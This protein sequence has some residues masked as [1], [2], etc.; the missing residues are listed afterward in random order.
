MKHTFSL[1]RGAEF[2]RAWDEGKAWSH[3]RVI[4][5]ARANGM[6]TCRFGFVAGKKIGSIAARNRAKR[7]L[8]EAVR[9]HLPR[10]APG[11][12][13]IWI[14]RAGGESIAFKEID[15]AVA[16]LVQRAHLIRNS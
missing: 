9:R 11:W 7:L 16:A 8:R 6:T 3:P 4:L 13:L 5:R 2:Q 1:R 14:A 15:D 10:I 12:D